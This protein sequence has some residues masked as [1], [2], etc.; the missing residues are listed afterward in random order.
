EKI[1]V[2]ESILRET[3]SKSSKTTVKK[4][5]EKTNASP[6]PEIQAKPQTREEKISEMIIG[7]AMKYPFLIEYSQN[8]LKPEILHKQEL[9][10]LY[11][12]LLFYYNNIITDQSLDSETGA[13]EA[14]NF[15]FQLFK[16]WLILK[17]GD[18]FSGEDSDLNN[19]KKQ[20]SQLMLLDRLA[21]LADEEYYDFEENKAKEEI[22]RLSVVLRRSYLSASMKDVENAIA[23]AETEKNTEKIMS[24]IKEFK[25]LADELKDIL[26]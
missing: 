24:L 16:D 18:S 19:E 8:H 15:E 26:Q 11:K 13:V 10:E 17:L 5:Y 6:E 1:D 2:S 25:A 4:N 22:I 12:N 14:I 21:L 20:S 23:R 7:L 9:R 3:I